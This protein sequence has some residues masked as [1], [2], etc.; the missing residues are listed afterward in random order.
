MRDFGEFTAGAR[1]SARPRRRVRGPWLAVA[2]IF[3]AA[4]TLTLIG[5]LP[6]RDLVSGQGGP[7]GSDPAASSQ[8]PQATGDPEA[9]NILLM[10]LDG[11]QDPEESGIQRADTLMVA[12]LHQD[13]GEVRLLS[14]P[15]DLYVEGVGPEGGPD[16][17]NSAYAYGGSEATVRA[18]ESFTGLPVDQ[19]VAADFEGFEETVDSLG[20]VEVDVKMDYL[21]HRGMPPGEQ[22][23]DGKEALLYARYR[24]T[25]RGDLDR[26]GRQQQILA[27]LRS[28][29]L[30]W[31]SITSS[32]GIIRTLN[33]H[34]ET[35]MGVPRMLTLGRALA[36]SDTG[37]GIETDQLEGRPVTLDDGREVLIPAEER[38]ERILYDF[39]R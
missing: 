27:A 39:L 21:S 16:R 30:S 17:I 25:P 32:P 2:L 18:V 38:N 7:G 37:G 5:A 33:D 3:S 14:I 36:Q 10:G 31:E 11:G 15:R 34:V 23:L 6:A 13:T 1:G 26:V 22:V 29:V 9:I 8:L 4:L 12:R 24:K 35:D 20:G 19:H 28:Q